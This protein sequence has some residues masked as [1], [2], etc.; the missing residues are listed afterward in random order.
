MAGLGEGID[1]TG[2]LSDAGRE[3]ALAALR[4]FALLIRQMGLR[5]VRAVAT[6]AVRDASNG[7][8]FLDQVRAIGFA[9]E[10]LS[11]EEEAEVAGMGVLSATPEAEG[12]VGDL[13][14]G[15]LELVE[16]SGGKAGKGLS[17]PLGVLRPQ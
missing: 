17:L 15:S 1:A 10:V 11:G 3:R 12:I 5:K 9:P 2:A 8:D 14:G 7:T 16:V 4:R 6:S 13:G